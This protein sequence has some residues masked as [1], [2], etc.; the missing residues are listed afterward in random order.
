MSLPSIMGGQAK[1]WNGR[2]GEKDVS[3]WYLYSSFLHKFS[4]PTRC[5]PGNAILN[6]SLVQ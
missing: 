4:I 5:D 3:T 2:G 1:E 6:V